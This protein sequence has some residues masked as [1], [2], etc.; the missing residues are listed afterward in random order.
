LF[1]GQAVVD[2]VQHVDGAFHLLV[3]IIESLNPV[4][5]PA[6]LL[7]NAHLVARSPDL[8]LDV[9]DVRSAC[10][11]SAS[12]PALSAIDVKETVKDAGNGQRLC[13][14]S[15]KEGMQALV[16]T[17]CVGCYLASLHRFTRCV[18]RK[19]QGAGKLSGA[20]WLPVYQLPPE[21]PRK[22]R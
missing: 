13:K 17:V 8:H 2:R 10:E 18:D 9:I 1:E 16:R 12:K 22:S 14:G 11:K 3:D 4:G 19:E 5:I 15:R 20:Q 7:P 6:H 21:S